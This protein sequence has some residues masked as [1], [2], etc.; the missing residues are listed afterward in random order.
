[1]S[2]PWPDGKLGISDITSRCCRGLCE[3]NAGESRS[4]ESARTGR[5]GT[6]EFQ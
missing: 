4:V 1:M 3:R 5:C 2:I 6:H